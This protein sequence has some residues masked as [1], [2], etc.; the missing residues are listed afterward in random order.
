MTF[1]QVR[2]RGRVSIR[3]LSRFFRARTYVRHWYHA[4]SMLSMATVR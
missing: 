4:E 1:H 2:T 3:Q